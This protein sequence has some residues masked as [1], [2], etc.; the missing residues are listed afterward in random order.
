MNSSS[1]Q[2]DK[3]QPIARGLRIASALAVT[4]AVFSV[5]AAALSGLGHR[6]GW[7][8]FITGFSILRWAAYAGLC[9]A[10]LA[11]VI[12]VGSAWFRGSW[13][14]AIASAVALVLALATVAIPWSYLR[15]AR[16]VPPIHDITTDTENPP[17]FV[18]VLALRTDAP[19]PA[20][21]GGAQLAAQQKQAYPDL[22]PL[23]SDTAPEN[24]FV[25]VEAVARSMG[26][27]IVAAVPAKG[28][29]EA[30]D[31]TFWYGFKDDIVVRVIAT[32]GGSHVDVRSVSRV[33]RSDIGANA[34]RIRAFL[35]KL[36]TR[37]RKAEG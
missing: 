17:E 3:A 32:D 35:V 24:I 33:G 2:A 15:V 30:T 29:L 16:L 7:G 10:V 5:L 6:W 12:G 31:T 11:A 25:D 34:K 18:A 8:S 28:R 1:A 9:T 26:W 36:A 4:L 22:A 37:V 14:A 23:V 13:R 20:T 19:N 27:T 21:Y